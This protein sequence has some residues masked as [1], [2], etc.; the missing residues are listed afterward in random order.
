MPEDILYEIFEHVAA[1][2]ENV[3]K[4][5]GDSA[6]S[7]EGAKCPFTLATVCS[8]WRRVALALP[9]LWSYIRLPNVFVGPPER[10][11]LHDAR[12]AL[13]L[14]R[15]GAAPLDI[16]V[17]L[18]ESA[19]DSNVDRL[20]A[21]LAA[22]A[23]RWKRIEITFPDDSPRSVADVFKLPLPALT[24]LALDALWTT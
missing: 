9:G 13:L 4:I 20:L 7:E 24:E 3:D 8:Q 21:Q 6:Y 22:H 18:A 10:I 19:H 2:H 23:C 16:L 1:L 17:K 15:S 5:L 11:V 14:S 12:V